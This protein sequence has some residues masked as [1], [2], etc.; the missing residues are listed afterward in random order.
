MCYLITSGATEQVPLWLAAVDEK[1]N[2]DVDLGQ[3]YVESYHV[4]DF[5]PKKKEKI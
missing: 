5:A 4:L 3:L 1:V 2:F